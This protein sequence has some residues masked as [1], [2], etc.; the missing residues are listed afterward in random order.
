MGHK[1]RRKSFLLLTAYLQCWCLEYLEV[2]KWGK[3]S[4]LN[5]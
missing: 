5:A 3:K 2:N 1:E 4:R